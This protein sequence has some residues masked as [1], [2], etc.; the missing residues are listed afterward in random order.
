MWHVLAFD[1]QR[2][3][4]KLLEREVYRCRFAGADLFLVGV[5]PEQVGVS[6]AGAPRSPRRRSELVASLTTAAR[7][8]GEVGVE[9]RFALVSDQSLESA[10]LAYALRLEAS[11]VAI[12][13][14]PSGISRLRGR[15]A[16]VSRLVARAGA[17]V[18][19]PPRE[20][21]EA[22]SLS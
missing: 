12:A 14:S 13:R 18:P 11:S 17:R 5:V 9:V 8:A 7:A 4:E 15:G 20:S 3:I 19:A 1:D 10:A 22:E 6:A 2:T 16:R 21:A